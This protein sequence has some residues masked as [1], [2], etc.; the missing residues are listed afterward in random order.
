MFPGAQKGGGGC[1]H[2]DQPN[3]CGRVHVAV[4]TG[5]TGM[6]AV[7]MVTCI[8]AVAMVTGSEV[9]SSPSATDYMATLT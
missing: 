7:A 6:A 3:W 8:A 9:T 4:V 5:I 2:G 1:R